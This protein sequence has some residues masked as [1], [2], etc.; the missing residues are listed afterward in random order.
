MPYTEGVAWPTLSGPVVHQVVVVRTGPDIL[1]PHVRAR[2][3]GV[4]RGTIQFHVDVARTISRGPRGV[5]L[6]KNLGLETPEMV[7]IK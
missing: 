4:L 3:H 7:D 2:G 6:V 5:R 1:S